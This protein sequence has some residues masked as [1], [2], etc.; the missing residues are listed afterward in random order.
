MRSQRILL[1]CSRAQAVTF[2]WRANGMPEPA[3]A[4]APFTDV[5]EEDYFHKAVLWAVE[6]GVTEGVSA[7]KF[8]PNSACSRGQIV[9]LLWRAKGSP[10]AVGGAVFNDVRLDAYY[11]DAVKWAVSENITSGTGD[12]SFSPDNSCT[13]G[14]IVTF[15]YRAR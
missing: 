1:L 3:S 13:R 4:E 11:A 9:T 10:N 6:T 12:A 5:Q 2:L 8:S 14:Q 7:T 15:L